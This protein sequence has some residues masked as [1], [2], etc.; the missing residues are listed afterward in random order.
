MRK[1]MAKNIKD[2]KYTSLRLDVPQITWD[3]LDEIATENKT[4]KSVIVNAI[5]RDLGFTPKVFKATIDGDIK[6]FK[7]WPE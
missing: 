5:L 7:Y 1:F 2:I 6:E 3:T 4:S